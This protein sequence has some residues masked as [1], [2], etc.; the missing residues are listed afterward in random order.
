L[1]RLDSVK[2]EFEDDYSERGADT[3]CPHT[4]TVVFLCAYVMMMCACL[5]WILR[6]H[7]IP[8]GADATICVYGWCDWTEV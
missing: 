5:D 2:E 4:R 1:L 7:V 6:D 8:R 3:A